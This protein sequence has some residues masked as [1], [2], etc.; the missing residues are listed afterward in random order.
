MSQAVVW[1]SMGGALGRYETA[2]V[3]VRNILW[4]LTGGKI[5]GVR[6]QITQIGSVRYHS[7][8]RIL[9]HIGNEAAMA[10]EEDG[11]DSTNGEQEM[12]EQPAEVV[13]AELQESAPEKLDVHVG[14]TWKEEDWRKL[15]EAL[16]AEGLVQWQEVAAVTLGELNPPQVGT[17]L[18]SNANIKNNYPPR[19]AWQAVKAWFYSQPLGC[20]ECRT[21]LKLEAEHIVPREELG[22]EA[23]KLENLQLLCKRCNAKKRPSHKNAGLTHLTAE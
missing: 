22:A 12:P 13:E 21:L 16:V 1:K 14:E 9:A 8:F 19:K 20:R 11:N 6:K 7:M 5:Q 3:G 18:A 4:G 15:V 23:D 2:G 17:S 10:V